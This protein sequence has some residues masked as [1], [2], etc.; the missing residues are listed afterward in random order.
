MVFKAAR[1]DGLIDDDPSEF[2]DTIKREKRSVRRAFTVEEIG[3][4]LKCCEGEWRSIVICGLYT[5]QRL[6][7]LACLRWS[8]IDMDKK[9]V[10]LIT[11][12]T[13]RKLTIPI[14]PAF[15]SHLK[16]LPVAADRNTPV[17][18]QAAAVVG[19]QGRV[20]T[21]SNQFSAILVKAGFRD[22]SSLKKQGTGKGRQAKREL[23]ELSFHSLRHTAVTL[24]KEA[25]S[26]AAVVM[27]LI[28]HD[29]EQMSEHYTHVGS[30][31]LKQAAES[32]PDVTK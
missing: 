26:P 31:A 29:S 2:V 18:P 11:R 27:E 28:G 23:N 21:L 17:H 16:T 22:A 15:M 1:R 14:A 30:E 32:L 3:R 24:L 10:S 7:D 4:V 19:K 12:K 5:G 6:A 13:D 8:N 20:G 9:E 25:G